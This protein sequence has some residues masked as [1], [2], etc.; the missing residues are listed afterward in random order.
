MKKLFFFLSLIIIIII[1]VI[2][3]TFP[4]NTPPKRITAVSIPTPIPMEI[5]IKSLE[6]IQPNK[7]SLTDLKN[8]LGSPEKAITKNGMTLFLYPIPDTQRKNKVYISNGTVTYVSEEQI[9]DNSLYS[10]FVK[11]NN[12]YEDGILYDPI[13]IGSGLNWYVF[14]NN[15][16]AFLADKN[17]GY[18]IQILRFPPTTYNNFLQT[19]A[20]NLSL[21]QTPLDKNEQFQ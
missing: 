11:N 9:K 16:I 15:G 5:K 19:T 18:T 17:S 7:T 8:S 3:T 6:E 12:K 14:A 1:I 2:I 21:S 20:K 4:K 10:D 13:Q